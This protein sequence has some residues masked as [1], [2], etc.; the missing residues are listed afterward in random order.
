[1]RLSESILRNLKEAYR[2]IDPE[3][4]SPDAYLNIDKTDKG[5]YVNTG[6]GDHTNLGSGNYTHIPEDEIAR[7]ADEL[8]RKL[9]T[10]RGKVKVHGK[11]DKD[12]VARLNSLIPSYNQ[13]LD[14][15]LKDLEPYAN[16]PL[17]RRELDDIVEIT[18]RRDAS[19]SS[20]RQRKYRGDG[21][22]GR[23]ISRMNSLKG[24]IKDLDDDSLSEIWIK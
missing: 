7:L 3:E 23:L 5:W 2:D 22:Y 8:D 6:I 19:G 1:M 24:Y 10:V 20:E 4:I 11:V 13:D 12:E 9:K 18:N 16:R 15:D 21:D 17:K 14:Q